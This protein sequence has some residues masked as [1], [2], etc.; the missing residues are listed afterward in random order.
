MRMMPSDAGTQSSIS[1]VGHADRMEG[2][3]TAR[4]GGSLDLERY[5]LAR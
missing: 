5:L 3:A 1:L 4:A 2:T